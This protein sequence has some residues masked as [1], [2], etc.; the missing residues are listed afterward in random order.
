MPTASGSSTAGV[1]V[2][3]SGKGVQIVAPADTSSR[4]LTIYLGAQ[5]ATGTLTAHLSDGSAADYTTTLSGSQSRIGGVVTLRYQA[6]AAGQTLTV[7]WKQTSGGGSGNVSLQAAALTVAGGTT[8]PTSP[9]PTSP[10]PTGPTC[11]CSIWSASAVPTVAADSDTSSV[12]L[13]VKFKSDVAGYITGIKFYKSS[14]NTGTH[15]GSLWSANGALLARAT[16]TNETYSGWQTVTFSTPVAIAA[17]TVYVASY[18]TNVGRYAGD[19]GYFSGSGVDNGPL[20]ALQDGV[21]GGNGVY[22]YSAASAFPNST[23]QA[24]NYWVDVLFQ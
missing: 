16:F 12:E 19:N 7:T 23:Y 5:N 15:V 8:T 6:K 9:T 24:S 14:L 17:N 10:T 4:T 11:P 18:H 21:T 20:H 1:M 2:S 3:G 22:S 13:G